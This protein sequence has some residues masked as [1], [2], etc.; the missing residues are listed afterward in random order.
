[1]RNHAVHHLF[2]CIWVVG[3]V[4][5]GV[6][7]IHINQ[8]QVQKELEDEAKI[9]LFKFG[10]MSSRGPTAPKSPSQST[11]AQLSEALK[12][13]Q[14]AFLYYSSG[15][16]DVPTQAK[17]NE[18][19]CANNDMSKGMP[20]PAADKKELWK[21]KRLTWNIVNTP[22]TLTETQIRSAAREAFLKWTQA[23][24]FQFVES[25]NDKM[26]DITI[27]FYD[28]PQSYLKIAASASKPVQSH[29]ILD[30]NQEWAYKI[31]TPR[32][33]S[34]FHTL[35]HEIG[36][37][38]GLP[39]SFY[40]GSI[41]HP[42]F[43]PIYLPSGT[44]DDVPNVDRLE[45]RK[46]YGLQS[47][48][49]SQTISG[50]PFNSKCP[51]HIDSIAALNDREWLLF[52]HDK[53]YRVNDRM[54]VD[55]GRKIQQVFPRGPQF[56]NATVTSGGLLLLFVERTIY[57]YENDGVTFSEAPGYPKELHDRVLFYPQ[58][59]FPLNNGSV[60]LL[61]GNVFATYNIG[62][63][64]PSF[65]NDKNRYFPNL[66]VDFHSGIE[67]Q[68]GLADAYWMF[69]EAT[70]SDYD[71]NAKQVLQIQNIPDFLKCT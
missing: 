2:L 35:L 20:I 14:A 69:D 24:G 37:V 43:K 7:G 27:T 62:H 63:N 3:V 1:M 55:E 65:L 61:S 26:P 17:M 36:H 15:I 56:V 18:W 51:K 23:T 68:Q 4:R 47:T 46:L 13:F 59:A 29:I 30:K 60:I 9:Y 54:F 22:K 53:V 21:K 45:F 58:G 34:L 32:G 41:M 31:E 52:R 38:L 67:K 49:D 19:R 16:V 44:I 42:I 12:R 66:P 6:P 25:K 5:A 64:S 11:K 48:E 57:G 39:H 71:M 33:I 50:D 8:N 10:Y 28:V 70:V 40:R